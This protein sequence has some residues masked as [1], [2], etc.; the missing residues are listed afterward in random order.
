MDLIKKLFNDDKSLFGIFITSFF[1]F[2][3][4]L[5]STLELSFDESYYWIYSEYLDWGYFDHPPMV[6]LIIKMGT[7]IFG[8]TEMGVRFFFNVLMTAS[9]YIIWLM[10]EKKHTRTMIIMML[11][12]PL[13]EMKMAS[14][15]LMNSKEF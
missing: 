6:G 10:L 8:Q 13:M 15:Q 14:S 3:L 9:Y 2:N 5:N 7:S 1:I 11:S 12:M 4:Y